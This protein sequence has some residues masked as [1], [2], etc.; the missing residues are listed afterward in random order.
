MPACAALVPGWTHKN[1]P[2]LR[3][4]VHGWKIESGRAFS[5]LNLAFLRPKPFRQVA[6]LVAGD[7]HVNRRGL[8]PGVTEPFLNRGERD[9]VGEAGHGKTVPQS[10]RRSHPAGDAGAFHALLDHAVGRGP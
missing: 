8:Q 4:L 6:F 7:P 2:E 5:K 9:V 3:I 10:F 1:E